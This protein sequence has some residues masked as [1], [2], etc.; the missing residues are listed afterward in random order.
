MLLHLKS[1]WFGG[2]W[3]RAPISKLGRRL[4]LVRGYEMPEPGPSSLSSGS[5]KRRETGTPDA[6][7]QCWMSLRDETA[8]HVPHAPD[9]SAHPNPSQHWLT[10]HQSQVSKIDRFKNSLKNKIPLYRTSL[11]FRQLFPPPPTP[12]QAARCTH[13]LVGRSIKHRPQ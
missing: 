10:P 1:R 2:Q 4:R 8:L 13:I 6:E 3:A 12:T 7:C 11:G 9:P 5:P